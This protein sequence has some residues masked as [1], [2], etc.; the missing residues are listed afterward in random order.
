[1]KRLIKKSITAG[2]GSATFQDKCIFSPSDVVA[3]LGQIEELQKKSIGL[4]PDKDGN[5]LLIVGDNQYV[6]TDKAQ[7]VFV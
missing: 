2:H 6:M 1:M 5:L 4:A 3:L 7:M